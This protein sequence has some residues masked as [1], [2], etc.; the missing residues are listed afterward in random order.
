MKYNTDI[1]SFGGIQDYHM[2]HESLRSFLNQETDLKERIINENIFGIRTEEGRG[3][4][5][6][7]INSTILAFKNVEHQNIY[8]AFFTNLDNALPY[9]FLIFWQLVINNKLFGI[10]TKNLYLKYYFS[11]KSTI[12][13]EDVYSYIMHLKE[14][15]PDFKALNWTKKTIEPVASKYLTVL[16]KLGFVEG[17]QIKHIKHIQIPDSVLTIYLYLLI[18]VFPELGNVQEHEYQIYSFISKESFPERIKKLALKD[19]IGMTYSGKNLYIKPI[20]D[21]KELANVLYYRS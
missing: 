10:L 13:G 19:L 17:V 15:D 20:I 5:Y 21:N 1:N 18:A 14:I 8:G 12:T 2:I 6:R 11:G 4:F 3:R 7:G 16:R 9:N